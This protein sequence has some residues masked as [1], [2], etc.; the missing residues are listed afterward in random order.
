MEQIYVIGRTGNQPFKIASESVHG[1]H[2]KI[3]ITEQGKWILEDLKGEN[4]NGTY[5][6]DEYGEFHRVYRVSITPDTIIRLANGGHRSYTFMAHRVLASENDF[7]YEFKVLSRMYK[8]FLEQESKREALNVRHNWV[9]KCSTLI[10]YL[11]CP[12]IEKC[13][14]IQIEANLRYA[15]LMVAPMLTGLFFHH[16]VAKLRMMKERRLKIVVCPNCRRPLSDYDV[17][18]MKCS[19]CKAK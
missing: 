12:V 11:S 4:G 8:K 14:G 10:P 6:Q 9:A 19:I 15:L 13:T 3:T 5:I 2:A 7:S 1:E 17:N 18:N 16:D